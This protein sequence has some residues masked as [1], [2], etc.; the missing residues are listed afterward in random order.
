MMLTDIRT[1]EEIK[2]DIV[3]Q[4][5]W[6]G[7]VDAS[8]ITV[9]VQD[10]EVTLGGTVSTYTAH[11]AAIEDAGTVRGVSDVHVQVAIEHPSGDRTCT[12]EEIR[13]NIASTLGWNPD[14]DASTI[15]V[16]VDDGVITLAG[17]VSA[18]WKKLRAEEI[19]SQLRGVTGARN[20]LTVVP[21][22]NTADQNIAENVVAAL[23]RNAVID[24]DDITVNVENGL[25]TL[26]GTVPTP[27]D[28][29]AARV[30]A[31]YT[32]GVLEVTEAL[33]VRKCPE[34]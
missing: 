29:R 26:S 2:T 31:C 3:E 30:A 25:V 11:K 8:D 12:D 27:S 19:A 18:V 10:G 1:D 20:L 33:H 15:D 14:I 34:I 32:E 24:A 21:T 6:D 28:R 23:K 17:S 16:S 5:R 13:R 7:R 9:A 22:T 4:L